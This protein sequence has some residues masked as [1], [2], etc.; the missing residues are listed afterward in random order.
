MNID[1]RDPL[2][3]SQTALIAEVTELR[4]KLDTCTKECVRLAQM[5]QGLAATARNN[6]ARNVDLRKDLAA[7]QAMALSLREECNALKGVK[8][9]TGRPL[10]RQ[11]KS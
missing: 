11:A 7:A 1:R 10:E 8:T 9:H 5:N 2:V 4:R 3:M 6:A